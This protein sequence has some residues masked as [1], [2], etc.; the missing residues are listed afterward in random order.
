MFLIFAEVG[1]LILEVLTK[2]DHFPLGRAEIIKLSQLSPSHPTRGSSAVVS[3]TSDKLG[4]LQVALM[5]LLVTVNCVLCHCWNQVRDP[6][7]QGTL[8][9]CS[10]SKALLS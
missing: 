5:S 1:V 2:P 4:E 10:L 8:Q 6:A 9:A 7:V 3:P